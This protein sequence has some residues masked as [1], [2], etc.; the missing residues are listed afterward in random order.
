MAQLGFFGFSDCYTSLDAQKYPLAEINAI[1]LWEEFRPLATA[2]L[3]P[4]RKRA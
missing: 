1:V 2:G 3:A 4:A